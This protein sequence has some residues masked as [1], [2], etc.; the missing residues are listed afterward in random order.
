MHNTERSNV[1]YRYVL[2]HS[3]RMMTFDTGF[4]WPVAFIEAKGSGFAAGA[5]KVARAFFSSG[6]ISFFSS[7]GKLRGFLSTG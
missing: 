6:K 2:Y 5:V 7:A 1:A 4:L 3:L